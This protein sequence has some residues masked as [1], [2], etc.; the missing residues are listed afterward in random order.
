M[1]DMKKHIKYPKIGQFSDV[2][3]SINR[4]SSFVEMGN[5]GD[6]VYD[7]SLPKPKITF[8]GTDQTSPN[9]NL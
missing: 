2:V 3:T 8:N 6:P 5:E 9:I 4:Q 7:P 1:C